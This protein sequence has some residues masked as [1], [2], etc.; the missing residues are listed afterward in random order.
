VDFFDPSSGLQVHDFNPG[1][2]MNGVI[3]VVQ[4]PD[5][6]VVVSGNTITIHVANQAVADEIAF[7]GTVRI[8][9][10]LSFDITYT[11]SGM[12][13]KIVPTSRDPLS[14]FH[15]A[16]EMSMAT[17]SGTFSVSYNDGSFSATGIF[18]SSGMFGEVG[19]ERNGIFAG[20]DDQNDSEAGRDA[21]E[22]ES[23]QSS[24]SV[25]LPSR[26]R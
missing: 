3:W 26:P 20:G 9:S 7:P 5:D 1:I 4:I 2:A 22:Q 25:M 15:W 6:G 17:N 24:Q 21:T 13:R 18:S 23:V 10:T 16:G 8:P 11:K 12:P 19:T 14:A